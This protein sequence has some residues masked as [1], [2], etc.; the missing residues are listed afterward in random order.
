[1]DGGQGSIGVD[2]D[3]AL[4]AVSNGEAHID[5]L[6]DHGEGVL[7]AVGNEDE[8][9]ADGSVE[10]D[11]A[12]WIQV[13]VVVVLTVE[14]DDVNSN[15]LVGIVLNFHE[16]LTTNYQKFENINVFNRF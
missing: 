14:V 2:P 11:M 10:D 3:A 5:D 16:L 1:M 4:R 8:G 7:L 12:V 9:I 13:L 15:H 6:V